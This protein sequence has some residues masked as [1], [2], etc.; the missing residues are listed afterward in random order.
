M[1]ELSPFL[2][3]EFLEPFLDEIFHCL[4]IVVGD[5]LDVLH[6]GRLLRGQASVDVPE[7]I[8]LAVVEVRKLRKRDFAQGDEIFYFD[9]YPV[10]YERVFAEIFPERCRLA[11]VSPVN[12][13]DC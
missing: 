11:R 8:E 12:G 6:P 7:S 10:A 3:M 4:D 5:F 9:P 2:Y 13:G 1:H